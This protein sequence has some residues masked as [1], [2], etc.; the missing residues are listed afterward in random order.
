MMTAS[1]SRAEASAR[2]VPALQATANT[3][4]LWV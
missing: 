2:C 1:S 3:L 4:M